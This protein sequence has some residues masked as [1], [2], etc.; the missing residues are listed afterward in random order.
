MVL[1]D[2]SATGEDNIIEKDESKDMN[3]LQYRKK[4]LEQIQNEVVDIEDIS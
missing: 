3:D 4:Q 2:V 1:L